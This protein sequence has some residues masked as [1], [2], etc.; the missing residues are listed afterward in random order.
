M[1]LKQL[2]MYE[3]DENINSQWRLEEFVNSKFLAS[4]FLVVS[5]HGFAQASIAEDEKGADSDDKAALE[6]S[7]TLDFL[8]EKEVDGKTFFE[9]NVQNFSGNQKSNFKI[10]FFQ[11]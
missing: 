9:Q 4:V 1:L 7:Q 5:I 6:Y 2:K 10:L 3:Y 8:N 11:F